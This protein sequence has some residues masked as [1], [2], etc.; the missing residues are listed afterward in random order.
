MAQRSET[1]SRQ[2]RLLGRRYGWV[3][4]GSV[5]VACVFM[6]AIVGFAVAGALAQPGFTVERAEQADADGGVVESGEGA[7]QARR[8]L[9]H[10]DGAVANPGVYELTAESPRI[11]DA[12][13]SAGGLVEGADTTSMNLAAPVSDGEKVHVPTVGEGDFASAATA[14]V[15]NGSGAVGNKS[16]TLGLVNINTA[17][18][19][20]LQ[21]LN[22]VGEATASAIV[23]ERTNNGP[24][25]SPEDLMRVTGIGEKKFEKLKDQICV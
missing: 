20:E 14:P 2:I 3:A 5:L 21:T 15:G 8:V 7:T 10:V 9:V 19:T 16:Q 24:F 17:D 22:G 23:R 1:V 25:A 6:V 18:E 13:L 12:V 11:N 4:K